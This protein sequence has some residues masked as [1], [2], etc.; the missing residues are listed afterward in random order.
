MLRAIK[1]KE[2]VRLSVHFKD[3]VRIIYYCI[4]VLFLLC[5]STNQRIN[6]KN[7]FL[8]NF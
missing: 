1:M 2:N 5:E 7:F 8:I 3:F 4:S 6:D